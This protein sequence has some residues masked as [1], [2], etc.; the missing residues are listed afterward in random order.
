MDKITFL[1]EY[2]K[3]IKLVSNEEIEALN[4]NDLPNEWLDIFKDTSNDSRKSRLMNLWESICGME[5]K[6]TISYL[7]ERLVDVDLV[8]DNDSYAILYSVQSENNEI[9]Y[10]EGGAPESISKNSELQKHYSHIPVSVKDFYEKLHNGFFYFPSRAMGLVRLQNISCFEN[11]EWGIIE[12]LEEPLAINL[13][14]TFGF[15]E[16]GM[17]GYVAIN[18]QD[19]S[20][21]KATLWFTNDQP[22]YNLNFWDVVD[23][24]IV[25][26]LQDV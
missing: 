14:S 7:T 26:G 8:L 2:R 16:N 23:E 25:I 18:M 4:K 19:N 24:W 13:N 5:L 20:D 6:N 9:L 12:D 15:F 11:F 3:N 10:Y 22:E 17:G 21:D 1:K